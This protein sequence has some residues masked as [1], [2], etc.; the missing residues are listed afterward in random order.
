M[1]ERRKHYQGAAEDASRACA[2]AA[3]GVCDRGHADGRRRADAG[4]RAKPAARTSGHP[5]RRDRATAARLHAADPA[6]RRP[7]AAEHSGHHHQRPLVQRLRGRC[8]AHLHQC[9]RADR[10]EGSE[11]GD[12]RARARNR[13]HRR[14]TPVAVAPAACAGAGG[15]D[16]RHDPRHRRRGRRRA[17]R[18][19]H[20]QSGRRHS[21]PARDHPPLAAV[22]P[23]RPGGAGRSRRR[24][25]PRRHRPVG[26]G[27]VRHLQAAVRPDSVRRAER[28]SLYA[29][30]SDAGGTRRG[31]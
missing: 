29:V 15:V 31:P 24:E 2:C 9:R 1:I 21:R 12:R 13:P 7:R 20:R 14:R 27:H 26:Q 6:R 19:Q 28:R 25:V 4:A 18:R 30:A 16:H 10:R 8:Q 17:Q 23:A 5:R 11:R 3:D 22:L